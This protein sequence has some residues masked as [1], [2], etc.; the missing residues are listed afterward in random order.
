M[1][2]TIGLTK[3]IYLKM[4]NIRT[5]ISVVVLVQAALA[6]D[7]AFYTKLRQNPQENFSCLI[8]EKNEEQTFKGFETTDKNELKIIVKAAVSPPSEMMLTSTDDSKIIEIFAKTSIVADTYIDSICKSK[9]VLPAHSVHRQQIMEGPEIEKIVDGGDQSNRID[10]VFM[11]D[12]YTADER[13]QF[14]GDI[15][16]LT[17]EMFN[18]ETFRSYLP[19]FNIWAIY[20]ESNETGIGYDGAKDTPFRLYRERGQLR[21]IYT[22]N[23]QYAREV[24]RLTGPGGCDYPSLIGNDDYY[25][26]LGGEFVI[27]TKSNRTGT[28]VLRHEMGHNFVN[29]GEEYDNGQV[30]SGVNAAANL[31]IVENKWGHWLTHGTARAERA[32]FRLLEYPWADLELG[33]QMFTFTSDGL[34]SRWYLVVSVSAAGEEDSLEFVLDGE[35]L[36]WQT[37]GYED[38]EFYDWFG[39][40]ALSE[41]EHTFTVRSKTSYT[42]PTI[43]RMLCSVNLHE[44][45]NED[46]FHIDNSV[47]SAY[48]T[49]DVRRR[50]TYRPTNAGCLMRNMTH[51][52]LCSVC[53]EGMWYQFLQR[54]SLID[55][56]SVSQTVNSDRTKRVEVNTLK[57]AHLRAPG[58]EVDGES[59]EIRWYQSGRQRPEFND[60]FVINAE[61]GAWTV[62]VKFN[63]PEVRHDPNGLLHDSES[64]SVTFPVNSTMPVVPSL[65]EH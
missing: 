59:L 56:V 60:Q 55:D 45:G 27:S 1:T 9:K 53:K 4:T 35:I 14:F 61:G 43:P 64:F 48:P 65:Y 33:Q 22:G 54:I 52:E 8:L 23:A 18:G 13:E 36:P 63:S 7:K 57:L 29:V 31:T 16:R 40:E 49:W 24:C 41:G 6:A 21:G 28:V 37:R 42:H 47:I 20:V 46:E 30:Y 58:N 3:W 12:G 2:V 5:L 15:R 51:H 25:G 10:V 34:Y 26:G 38:R 62:A 44:F 19:L 11:G 17:E 32:I 39:D 50:V